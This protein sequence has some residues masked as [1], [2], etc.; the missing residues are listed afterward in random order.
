MDKI[1]AKSKPV[2]T[3]R[4]HTEKLL[5]NAR[6]LKELYPDK[7]QNKFPDPEEAKEFWDILELA[8]LYHDFGKIDPKFQNKIRK[9]LKERPIPEIPGQEI[10]HNFLSPVFIDRKKIIEKYGKE[11]WKI[12]LFSIIKHH[13]RETNL[14][15]DNIALEI[16][17]YTNKEL[18]KYLGKL[19]E[20]FKWHPRIEY[21]KI[22][23]ENVVHLGRE[24]EEVI[25]EKE[26]DENRKKHLIMKYVLTK[27]L[28]HRLDHSASAHVPVETKSDVP[29]SKNVEI[30]ITDKLKGELREPQKFA[31]KNR[32]N[33]VIMV[34]STG[35]GKTEAAL[36]WADKDKTFFT[37]PI[38]TSINSIYK[39]IT[40]NMDYKECGILHS[41]SFEYLYSETE[42]LQA[43]E[44]TYRFS[45][46]FSYPL[47][48]CTIDQLFT[49]PFKHSGYEKY[50]ATLSYSKVII[51]E[52]QSY[53][54]EI[55]A[56]LLS[57]I[58]QI[59]EYGGKFMIMTA[60]LPALY[61]EYLKE[62]HID[63]SFQEFYDL[64]KRHVISIEDKD[65]TEDINRIIELSKENSVLIITNTVKKSQELYEKIKAEK[66]KDRTPNV[67]LLN[68][69]FTFGDRA[70][71]EKEI[72]KNQKG[73]IW[74]STQIVEA[75]LDI[76]YDYLFTELSTADSLF[77]RMGRCYRKREY[78]S[79]KPNVF[80][81]TKN[82]SGI[83]HIYDEDIHELTLKYL[84]EF[85]KK[86]INGERKACIV[87]EI[88][89]EKT[90]KDTKYLEKFRKAINFIND[91]NSV[92]GS[93]VTKG[94]VQN[95]LR[96]ASNI[97]VI[98]QEIYEQNIE[99][100]E[101]YTQETDREEKL[102]LYM[103]IK[104]FMLDVPAY[105]IKN[106]FEKIPQIEGVYKACFKYDK[107]FG[108][109]LK[110][111]LGEPYEFI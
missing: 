23:P 20:E 32:E 98:P 102:K 58:T 64:Q 50:L 95:I 74:I 92:S 83:G 55:A 5:E 54:P 2:E 68:S 49:F 34:A 41:T 1:Y 77:Q 27:G 56:A 30:Y 8:A 31:L 107:E 111:E 4:E 52:I 84:K 81:Y 101:K 57:G 78:K 110:N 9:I 21:L 69:L 11:N 46:M 71:K 24:P 12:L 99:L 28:L 87:S 19:K 18:S 7:F 51:D 85:D 73:K 14:L 3:L 47:T 53:S 89:S 35:F 80:V 10:P 91:L 6:I 106:G 75:S 39:R 38:R 29:V 103:K 25:V 94:D 22:C 109:D 76:D 72:M 37:L 86:E 40:E 43:S 105:K 100:L 36:L 26:Q 63:Y 60:T 62:K 93:Q 66:I 33:N 65:I 67:E 48:V 45:R 79:D 104:E 15:G 90:L 82:P 13:E 61:I 70:I 42:D 59:A 97:T 96:D 88:Y 108:L 16:E 44:Y 17:E